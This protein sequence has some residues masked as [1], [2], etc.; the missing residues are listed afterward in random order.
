MCRVLHWVLFWALKSLVA[1]FFPSN[2]ACQPILL[3]CLYL[4]L[5]TGL[6]LSA[7]ANCLPVWKASGTCTPT[8]LTLLWEDQLAKGSFRREKRLWENEMAF[9]SKI[10]SVY[11]KEKSNI[12]KSVP[13]S[14]SWTKWIWFTLFRCALSGFHTRKVDVTVVVGESSCS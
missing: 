11:F 2:W 10:V 3:A 5:K 6:H 7:W 1:C 4:S 12:M 13:F 8:Q 14:P 9:G